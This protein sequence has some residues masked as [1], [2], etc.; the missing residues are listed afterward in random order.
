MFLFKGK[1]YIQIESNKFTEDMNIMCNIY[2]RYK[3]A[4]FLIINS[5]T[6]TSEAVNK[7]KRIAVIYD[8]IYIESKYLNSILKEFFDSQTDKNNAQ[9]DL[10][11]ENIHLK[12]QSIMQNV[13]YSSTIPMKITEE[14]SEEVCEMVINTS[15]ASIIQLINNVRRVDEYLFMHG[16]NVGIINGLMG[17]WLNL[18]KEDM[19]RLVKV[20]LLHDVGKAKIPPQI[21]NKPGKLTDQEFE[22]IKLHPVFSYEIA[23]RSNEKDIDILNGIRGHHEKINGTGYPDNLRNNE[24]C[25]FARITIISDIY[26]A[27]VSKRV[28]K[29]AHS[30][31]E[32]LD[33]FSQGRFS[34][35]D[36]EL[37]NVFLSNMPIELL[38]KFVLL[39]NGSIGKIIY[40]NSNN[41]I[42]PIVET[43]GKIILTNE[44]LKCVSMYNA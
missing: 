24:I 38:D 19:A 11:Y 9:L 42:Y 16:T 35:L 15:A 22:I 37:V 27:M 33:E 18:S 5:S 12:S 29:D 28:Y 4:L 21:I 17:K 31:F 20:G 32:V 39:S 43:Q 10:H 36:M 41:F 26:D 14:L 13:K 30:P 40:I 7:I 1:E 6:L 44:R 25:L 23:K 34:N 3:D 8:G 2:Y